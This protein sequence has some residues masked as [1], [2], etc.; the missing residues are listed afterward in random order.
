MIATG[1]SAKVPP[2][3]GVDADN[4][5]TVTKPYIVNKLKGNLDKYKN[6]VIVGGGFIGVEV[7][8]QLAQLNKKVEVIQSSDK[9]MNNPFDPEFS[10]QIEMALKDSG[11]C[12]RKSERA[13]EFIVEKNHVTHVKTNENSY[14]ADAVI[15]AVGFKP[16]T[17]FLEGQLD[18]LDNGALIINEFGE[19]SIKDV[20]SAGDCA[21]VPHRLAG[22]QYIPLATYANKLGRLI[23]INIVSEKKDWISFNGA[24]GSSAIKVGNYEAVVTGLTEKQAL[25]LGYNIKTTLIETSNHNDYYPD[26]QKITIKLVYDAK[27]YVLYGAQMFGK[28]DVVLRATGLTTAI[29]AGLTT[30]EIGFIDYAYSPPFASTWEALN[31]AANTAK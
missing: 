16:N 6:I 7:A 5:Y 14:K 22:D 1:A 29:H 2:I 26:K 25:N 15:L 27:N 8:E 17:E 28:Q 13:Q 4:V 3:Y 12:V 19:T 24:L 9:L 31:V 11:V 20:F 23:G 21:S 30:K 10:D 18:C